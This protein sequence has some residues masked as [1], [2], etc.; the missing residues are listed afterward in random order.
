ML[1]KEYKCLVT[2]EQWQSFL[3]L[4]KKKYGILC[5]EETVHVNYYYDTP[6][7][8]LNRTGL[9]QTGYP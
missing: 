6:D 4:M 8:A 1:E 3:C 2:K 7:F 5:P 9:F